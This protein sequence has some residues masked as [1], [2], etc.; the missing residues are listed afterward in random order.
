[1]S[2]NNEQTSNEEQDT[3]SSATSNTITNSNSESKESTSS[4]WEKSLN[5]PKSENQKVEEIDD[6]GSLTGYDCQSQTSDSNDGTVLVSSIAGEWI[7]DEKD[8]LDVLGSES[9]LTVETKMLWES[10]K[11]KTYFAKVSQDPITFEKD[12]SHLYSAGKGYAQVRRTYHNSVQKSIWVSKEA[13]DNPMISSSQPSED[14]QKLYNFKSK[15]QVFVSHIMQKP[16]KYTVQKIKSISEMIKN[17]ISEDLRQLCRHSKSKK[18]ESRKKRVKTLSLRLSTLKLDSDEYLDQYFHLPII[19][20]DHFEMI[21]QDVH[22]DKFDTIC[23]IFNT[24]F[25]R[26]KNEFDIEVKFSQVTLEG[27]LN[28]LT[29]MPKIS[30]LTFSS[31]DEW[32]KISRFDTFAQNDCSLRFLTLKNL[33]RS[34]SSIEILRILTILSKNKKVWEN[35]EDFKFV[36]KVTKEHDFASNLLEVKSF[37]F[38]KC[39]I[40][41]SLIFIIDASNG[42]ITKNDMEFIQ[43][44]I[45]KSFTLNRPL[46]IKKLCINLF[47][48]YEFEDEKN[49]KAK[50]ELLCKICLDLSFD[51][52]VFYQSTLKYAHCY[53]CD[54]KETT[55]SQKII[56][57]GNFFLQEKIPLLVR[58]FTENDIMFSLD[59]EISSSILKELMKKPYVLLDQ[60]I[61]KGLSLKEKYAIISDIIRKFV[62]TFDEWR[63]KMSLR[64]TLLK[65]PGLFSQ[66]I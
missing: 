52:K 5:L 32:N 10:N 1:M 26:K 25:E 14:L 9:S 66:D 39:K 50:L 15:Y 64:L 59:T 20:H 55:S 16:Q 62:S 54:S 38:K 35:L 56:R 7:G 44:D 22:E 30:H 58:T 8:D 21:F 60:S 61:M 3:S 27:M 53:F 24:V 43:L 63:L 33:D 48:N 12:S 19:H 6:A 31:W 18:Y 57:Y 29:K 13:I 45:I 41:G 51:S 40:F 37:D 49:S 2:F 34:I 46:E 17:N 65:N 23:E 47:E 4:N 42:K 11:M 28:I 36:Y